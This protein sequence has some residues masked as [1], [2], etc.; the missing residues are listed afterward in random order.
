MPLLDVILKILFLLQ[1]SKC[2]AF[3]GCFGLLVSWRS[4]VSCLWLPTIF[5]PCAPVWC[6]EF[7]GSFLGLLEPIVPGTSPQGHRE[8]GLGIPSLLTEIQQVN[9]FWLSSVSIEEYKSTVVTENS[10]DHPSH[11]NAIDF[12]LNHVCQKI[13]R[14][15]NGAVVHTRLFLRDGPPSTG[16][17][18]FLLSL[19][20]KG[21]LSVTQ[22]M[23]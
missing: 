17:K 3:T 1:T 16:I 4:F 15:E 5:V 11:R 6:G 20:Y 23:E 2:S 8:P 7:H 14:K 9:P 13:L 21:V 12:C 10:W 22:G 19:I 18:V